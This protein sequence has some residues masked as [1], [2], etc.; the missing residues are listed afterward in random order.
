MVR[1]MFIVSTKQEFILSTRGTMG[2]MKPLLVCFLL[3]LNGALRAEMRA[4]AAMRVITPDL[5]KHA[6]VYMA[7]F[8]H[9]RRATAIHD[10]L[11]ARCLAIQ[12]GQTPLIMCGVDSIGLFWEDVQRIRNS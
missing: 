9:N 2:H 6:P 11:Y 5:T 4:G 12:P 1:A 3:L 7:G 10:D 8:G